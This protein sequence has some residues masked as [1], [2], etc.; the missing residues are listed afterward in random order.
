[1]TSNLITAVLAILFGLLVLGTVGAFLLLVPALSLLS[2][3]SIL[4]ALIFMFV[5]GCHAGGRRI[6]ISH[7]RRLLHHQ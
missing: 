7:V 1:M 6:R 3:A 2:V 5:L 4:L